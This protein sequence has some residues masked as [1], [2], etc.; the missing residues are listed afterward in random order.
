MPY[1]TAE[2]KSE[3][4][5]DRADRL[6]SEGRCT[7][8]GNLSSDGYVVCNA[9]R[10]VGNRRNKERFDALKKAGICVRC[11]KASP[12]KEDGALCLTCCEKFRQERNKRK[13]VSK[14]ACGK[15]L[16]LNES[17][18]ESCRN[19]KK[20]YVKNLRE[21]G[22]CANGGCEEPLFPGKAYCLHHLMIPVLSRSEKEAKKRGHAP[23]RASLWVLRT[24]FKERFNRLNGKCEW[25]AEVL[26]GYN[27]HHNHV[28]GELKAI[29]CLNCN[30]VEGFGLNRLKCILKVHENNY[31]VDYNDVFESTDKFVKTRRKLSQILAASKQSAKKK[32]HTPIKDSLDELVEWYNDRR[33]RCGDR[34]EWCR[35]PFTKRGPDID[36]C[37]VTGRLRA[38]VCLKCNAAE[39]KGIERIKCIIAALENEVECQPPSSILI[40]LQQIGNPTPTT[41]TLVEPVT[42]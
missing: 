35:E 21:S 40:K 4:G 2:E 34:C 23:I 41:S 18:C 27:V 42:G 22:L 32:G 13:E 9:C 17:D 19:K 29:T 10:E 37:H 12:A 38:L 28:T 25:C 8:C 31:V 33:M 1:K 24:W 15:S 14:C 26:N 7:K 3:Y 6:R 5:R 11:E 39:G 36:H 20:A 16:L 30:L